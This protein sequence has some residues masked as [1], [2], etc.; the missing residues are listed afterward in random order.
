M[1]SCLIKRSFQSRLDSRSLELIRSK[2]TPKSCKVYKLTF[3]GYEVKSRN[4]KFWVC[5]SIPRHL[6]LWVSYLEQQKQTLAAQNKIKL[7]ISFKTSYFFDFFICCV[8]IIPNWSCCSVSWS[9]AIESVQISLTLHLHLRKRETNSSRNCVQSSDSEHIVFVGPPSLLLARSAYIGHA[10]SIRETTH[11]Q[12][13]RERGRSKS[14]SDL[15]WP[16]KSALFARWTFDFRASEDQNEFPLR[17]QCQ[18]AA[19]LKIK[20]EV[21]VC[22]GPF[23]L[24]SIALSRRSPSRYQKDN[25]ALP[26]RLTPPRLSL[27]LVIFFISACHKRSSNCFE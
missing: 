26:L 8:P 14:P 9:L 22:S 11:C 12:T 17:H 25:Q 20:G 7:K 6:L 5:H 27:F 2:I 24:F 10:K 23:W 16:W 4:V 19:R 3:S 13:W 1:S 21:D 18:G 15:P